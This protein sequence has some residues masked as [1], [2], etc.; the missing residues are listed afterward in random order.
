MKRVMI[1]VIAVVGLLVGGF[2]V[3]ERVNP[4]GMARWLLG[5][6]RGRAGLVPGRISIPEGQ[7]AYLSGGEGN[8]E[9]IVLIHGIGASKD[10]FTRVAKALTLKYRVVAIDLPGFGESGRDATLAY[11]IPSQAE[12]VKE[13]VSALGIVRFHL[14]GSSMGG[15]IAMRYAAAHPDDVRSLWLIDPAGVTGAKESPVQEIYRTTG[16]SPLFARRAEEFDQVFAWV[17]A[18]PPLLP[19][20]V[21]HVT[22][23]RMVADEAFHQQIFKALVG[24][25]GINAVAPTIKTP[26]LIIWG[27]QDRVLDLSGGQLLVKLLPHARLG[28]MPGLGH[29]SILEAP[30][31]AADSYLKFLGELPR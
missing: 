14:G 20:A 4:E 27:D 10:H 30:A 29:L 16:R 22:A 3:A 13:V 9:A 18:K 1:G 12:R 2:L 25:E 23:E 31:A 11:D 19:W 24:S 28:V 21:K 15:F 8:A 7:V 26:A 6:E 17:F 5:L